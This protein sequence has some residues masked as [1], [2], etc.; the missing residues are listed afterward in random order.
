M[1]KLSIRSHLAYNIQQA[2]TL[3]LVLR[4]RGGLLQVFAMASHSEVWFGLVWAW[5]ERWF[6]EGRSSTQP[7]AT[8]T[9]PSLVAP[10]RGRSLT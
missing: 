7:G 3:H 5:W 6:E 2:S 10:G 4:R 8:L 9:F 1:N